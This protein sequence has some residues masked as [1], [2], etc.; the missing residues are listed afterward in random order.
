MGLVITH[1]EYKANYPGDR[2]EN[3]YAYTANQTYY[4]TNYTAVGTVI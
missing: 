3:C 1:A 4:F 2:I